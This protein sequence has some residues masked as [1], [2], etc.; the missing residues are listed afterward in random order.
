MP[1]TGPAAG[2]QVLASFLGGLER[3]VLRIHSGVRA[4]RELDPAAVT[5]R[6]GELRDAVLAH[7]PGEGERLRETLAGIFAGL[8][9]R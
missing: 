7:A 9:G 1:R 5:A 6:I 8:T 3:R 4:D 2:H